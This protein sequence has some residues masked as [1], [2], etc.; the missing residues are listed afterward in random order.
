MTPHPTPRR[1]QRL[2]LAAIAVLLCTSGLTVGV[3]VGTAEPASAAAKPARV[4]GVKLKKPRVDGATASFKVTWKRAARATSYKVKWKVPGGKAHTDR[5][6]KTSKTIKK[7]A[8]GANYCVKVRAYNGKRKGKWSKTRCRTTPQL[9]PV[10]PV[11]VDAQ[12]Q[13]G[14]TIALGF[15]WNEVAGATSYEL[16]YAPGEKDIQKHKKKK[17]VTVR[18]TGTATAGVLVGGFKPSRTYCFQVRAT[19]RRGTGAWGVAGCKVTVPT[20]RAAGGPVHVN[21]MTWNVCANVCDGWASREPLIK[22]RITE[23]DSDAI[24]IQEGPNF[25]Y[26]HLEP[27]PRH[28]RG[29]IVGDG[30][31]GNQRNQTLFVRT[32]KFSIIP[33]TANGVR[34]APDTHGGCWVRVKDTVTGRELILAS[35]HLINPGAP[36]TDQDRWNQMQAFWLALGADPNTIGL[37]IVVAGDFNSTRNS[38]T[39]APREYLNIFGYDDAF[40]VAE[41]YNSLPFINSWNA[42]RNPPPQSWRWGEHVDRVFVSPGS[43]VTSWQ[44]E[45]P[46]GGGLQLSDHSAVRVTVD[47]P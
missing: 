6:R 3:V 17:V 12:Q 30:L 24:A 5:T 46:F 45:S 9:G 43:K 23:I 40:D 16:A 19:G 29:C 25:A 2:L 38:R 22:G 10:Q 47:I 32:A 21:M 37:P 33:G 39:D 44:M 13:Q 8:Q 4:K 20:S 7:L 27:L 41:R 28:Q 11:W 42:W 31:G 35:V 34:F 14:A 18:T 15:R 1:A 36:S 26:D